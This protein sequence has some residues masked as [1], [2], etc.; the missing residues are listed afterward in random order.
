MTADTE[1]IQ[2]LERALR[3][4]DDCPWLADLTPELVKTG[5]QALYRDAG[6]SSSEYGTSRVAGRSAC[7][8]RTVVGYLSNSSA[9]EIVDDS[10]AT[11]YQAKGIRFYSA[12]EIACL[13][14]VACLD[15]ALHLIQVLPTLS[16]TLAALVRCLHPL[17]SPHPDYDL[18]FSEPHLPFS[19]FVSIPHERGTI[20]ALRLAEAIVHEGMHLQLTL[21]QKIVPLV[22]AT[23]RAYFSPWRKEYRN[24]EGV[25]QGL[26]VFCVIDRFLETLSKSSSLGGKEAS[27]IR[28]RRDKIAQEVDH[29]SWLPHCQDL[30]TIG[31]TF[32]R[33][34]M[35]LKWL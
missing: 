32:T 23:S 31:S 17:K 2:R 28:G 25:L 18:S 19:I 8:P 21:V 3:K 20:G 24:L 15:D 16:T 22:K 9:V 14:I 35:L 13:D 34:L 5:W 10:L 33:G 12:S 26:Y 4:S 1:F 30:T 7:A 11:Y 29:V 27:H 6:I